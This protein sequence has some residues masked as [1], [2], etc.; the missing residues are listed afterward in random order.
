MSV[1]GALT[2]TVTEGKAITSPYTASVK[3]TYSDGTSK[4]LT[5]NDYSIE[6]T[7]DKSISGVSINNGT[8]SVSDSAL[9]GDYSLTITAK[10]AHENITGSGVK[11]ITLHVYEKR[12]TTDAGS[13]DKMTTDEK[14][15]IET[16]TLSDNPDKKITDL[17]QIDF[18]DFTN[19][20]TL[21]LSGLSNL[22]KAD[23][24]ELPA[25]VKDVNLQNTNITS[26]T[27]TGSTVEKV[28]AK[29]CSNLEDINAESNDSL[30]ELNVSSTNITS[31]NVKNC[32]N[33]QK[34]EC[35]SC[36]ID[37]E[38]LTLDGCGNLNY[39][40]I[41]ENH[42]SWFNYRANVL[43]S[44]REFICSGQRVA[45]WYGRK[46]FD[47]SQ[48]FNTGEIL[49]SDNETSDAP[50]LE[51]VAGITAYDESGSELSV[52]YDSESGLAEF[53]GTPVSIKYYYETGFNNQSM[54][55][56]IIAEDSE[57]AANYLG[58]SGGGCNFGFNL[59]AVILAAA[60]FT[61]SKR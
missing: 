61:V 43:K 46:T 34:L 56:T 7:L 11:N 50:N 53:S 58:S 47:F 22:E 33:L 57:E 51:K 4:T 1:T 55:V 8:L 28:N 26:L 38:N 44:L 2:L 9:Q 30:I 23:L 42:F 21:D 32:A 17:S 41:R 12:K 37:T 15:A 29:G 10:A 54:D 13:L 5:A 36:D 20:K 45:G 60:L 18:T 35:S 14:K 48:F 31:I 6:W 3:G 59:F 49:T 24:S 40:D 25:N 16:L 27:L 19:L 39:L 52:S